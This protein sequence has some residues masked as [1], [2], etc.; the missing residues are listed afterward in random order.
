MRHVRVLHTRPPGCMA[1]VTHETLITNSLSDWKRSQ[2]SRDHDSLPRGS[3]RVCAAPLLRSQP[4]RVSEL[5]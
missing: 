3:E 5:L 4:G 1:A 2:E